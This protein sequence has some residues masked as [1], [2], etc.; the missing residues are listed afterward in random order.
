MELHVL[1]SVKGACHKISVSSVVSSVVQTEPTLCIGENIYEFVNNFL[2]SV[3]STQINAIIIMDYHYHIFWMLQK[4]TVH[5]LHAI[6]H[7]LLVRFFMYL[8]NVSYLYKEM[9]Q[10]MII[11]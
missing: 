3:P 11:S 7:V 5:Y 10:N 4:G 8:Y 6:L 9:L 1:M 2:R